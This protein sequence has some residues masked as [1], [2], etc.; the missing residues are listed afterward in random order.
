MQLNHFII[1]LLKTPLNFSKQLQED[2]KLKTLQ[3]D[4]CQTDQIRY[5]PKVYSEPLRCSFLRKQLTV[6]S[7]SLFLRKA[8]C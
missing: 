3:F 1:P 8:L 6:E 4:S 5:S 7:L 2:R